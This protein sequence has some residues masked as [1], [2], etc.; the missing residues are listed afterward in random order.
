VTLTVDN[1]GEAPAEGEIT[2]TVSPDDAGTL[3]GP[4]TVRYNLPPGAPGG[5]EPQAASLSRRDTG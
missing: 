5:A 2:L 1:Y 3:D 4:A